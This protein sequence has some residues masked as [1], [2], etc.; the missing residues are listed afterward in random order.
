MNYE[1]TCMTEIG[2]P[3]A[4]DSMES[5]AYDVL[6]SDQLTAS[7]MSYGRRKLSRGTLL[8]LWGLR[9]YVIFMV[10]IIGLAVW[11]ML[12]VAA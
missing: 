5:W 7:K 6:E 1:A 12:H 2:E 3:G 8:L 11:N 10:A 9:G 4:L